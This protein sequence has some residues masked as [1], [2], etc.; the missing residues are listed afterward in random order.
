MLDDFTGLASCSGLNTAYSVAAHAHVHALAHA[1]V[2]QD[3]Q[4]KKA[5]ATGS[6]VYLCFTPRTPIVS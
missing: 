4:N 3:G 5:C 2:H 1:H 6:T